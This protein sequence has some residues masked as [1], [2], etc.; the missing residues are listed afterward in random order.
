MVRLVRQ[1]SSCATTN[2]QEIR[3]ALATAQKV[4][5]PSLPRTPSSHRRTIVNQVHQPDWPVVFVAFVP[6]DLLFDFDIPLPE[7]SISCWI[8]STIR[9]REFRGAGH[10]LAT[11]MTTVA[12]LAITLPTL[13]GS[14]AVGDRHHHQHETPATIILNRSRFGKA[15]VVSDALARLHNQD[16]VFTP[17][18]G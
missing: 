17:R 8:D 12:I 10:D 14:A 5:P 15:R 3:R 6:R 9:W 7:L 1:L 4:P 13:V 18:P 2:G 11:K 16:G